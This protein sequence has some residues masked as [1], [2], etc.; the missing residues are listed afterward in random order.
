ML[1]SG[2]AATCTA[3]LQLR[4]PS[5]RG[6]ARG[7]DGRSTGFGVDSVAARVRWDGRA[8]VP[9]A[10]V[11]TQRPASAAS[12]LHASADDLV[13]LV[14]GAA[15]PQF[16][17]DATRRRLP[18]LTRHA[19]RTADGYIGYV[20]VHGDVTVALLSVVDDV[21]LGQ[22]VPDLVAL[23]RGDA[24]PPRVWRPEPRPTPPDALGACE[25]R[26]GF[27]ELDDGLVIALDA[28]QP[29]TLTVHQG[30][31]ESRFALTLASD[32]EAHA[33]DPESNA[34]L[35]LSVILSSATEDCAE[36]GFRLSAGTRATGVRR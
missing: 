1:E 13:R 5:A 27:P 15:D 10:S 21:P 20:G 17:S 22:V 18:A 6:D 8:L 26:F 25:G 29:P 4:L 12:G 24:V 23:A 33:L 30:A 36:V 35:P 31:G 32:G 19:G 11:E 28:G 7:E 9:L 34:V 3:L 2:T 14:R 16:V